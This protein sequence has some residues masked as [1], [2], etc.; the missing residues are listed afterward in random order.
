[1]SRCK[2][3]FDFLLAVE[4]FA[5][6]GALGGRDMGAEIGKTMRLFNQRECRIREDRRGDYR[7]DYSVGESLTLQD[8]GR[9][10]ILV[11]AA[12]AANLRPPVARADKGK[13]SDRENRTC[14]QTEDRRLDRS[15]SCTA[16]S[17]SSAASG[18][19]SLA[20]GRSGELRHAKRRRAQSER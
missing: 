19:R 4:I 3:F 2:L 17:A 13:A 1:M 20:E 18:K 11:V 8:A 10:L 12:P 9:G 15:R 6:I 5:A 14:K 16:G 7:G